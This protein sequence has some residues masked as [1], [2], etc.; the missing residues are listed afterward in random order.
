MSQ[1]A[2]APVEDAREERVSPAE[3]FALLGD[4]T[5]IEILQALLDA[6]ADDEPVS[7]S[8]LYGRTSLDDSAHFNYHLKRLTDHFV[9][10]TDDGYVFRYPGWKVV[11]SVFAGSFTDRAHLDPFPAPGSCSDCGGD[12]RAWY[13]EERLGVDCPECGRTHVHHPFPPGGIED[14]TP[15]ELLDAFH[16]HVRHH[17]CLAADGV[18]P[19]CMG[20]MRTTLSTEPVL[21]D[22]DV[23]ARHAC[24]RCGHVLNSAVGLNL[25]DDA[26]VLSFHADRGVDLSTEPFWTFD[27]CVSDE[28]TTIRN[29]DPL[30]VRLDIPCEGDTLCVVLDETLSVLDVDGCARPVTTRGTD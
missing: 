12:L 10:R 3:A 29:A 28:H 23:E 26:T 30:E 8:E 7:F 1:P 11:R 5:R 24:R 27:W 9:R 2:D 17:Y 25:L 13:D 6:G 14:R 15:A 20:R 4:E 19:E 18:C 22:L 16:H 21:P